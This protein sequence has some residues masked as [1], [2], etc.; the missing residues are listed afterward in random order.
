[1]WSFQKYYGNVTAYLE[2]ASALKAIEN[3]MFYF[4][5]LTEA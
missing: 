3:Y 2:N 5:I 1:M 4:V